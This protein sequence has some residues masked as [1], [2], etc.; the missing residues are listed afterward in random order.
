M[1][2]CRARRS[3][4][5]K[6]HSQPQRHRTAASRECAVID[7]QRSALS[8]FA[9]GLAGLWLP[10]LLRLLFAVTFSSTVRHRRV[11]QI[12]DLSS[13]AAR[14]P[15]K[16]PPLSHRLEHTSAKSCWPRS[17]HSMSYRNE[18]SAGPRPLAT[19]SP[20]GRTEQRMTDAPY[21]GRGLKSLLLFFKSIAA[22]V[23]D[24]WRSS[25]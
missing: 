5:K 11:L 1:S 23:G 20:K 2:W 18:K 9:S 12:G 16:R 3:A 25:L 8:S 10:F 13:L 17:Q 4:P 19:P 24:L 15:R 21:K 22:Q 14:K 6:R 7:R